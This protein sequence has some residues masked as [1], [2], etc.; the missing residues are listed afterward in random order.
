MPVASTRAS[1]TGS[2]LSRSQVAGARPV[3]D[4]LP[5][6]EVG[7]Q[8]E[9]LRQI[10]HAPLLGRHAGQ[11]AAGEVDPSALQGSQTD[12]DFEQRGFAGAGRTE[13][14]VALSFG[15]AQRDVLE[16]KRAGLCA[17]T[18]KFEHGAL[19]RG[20][21]PRRGQLSPMARSTRISATVPSMSALERRM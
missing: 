8:V 21:S 16:S 20:T 2:I 9:P 18:V 12:D 15:H 11:V 19:G 5:H 7:K 4:V 13:E 17:D 6:R 3:D 10:A 1:T 14:H